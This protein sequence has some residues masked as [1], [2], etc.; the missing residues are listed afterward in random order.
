MESNGKIICV[1][2]CFYVG[3]AVEGAFV[4]LFKGIFF[5]GESEDNSENSTHNN[6][7][8][9]HSR[10]GCHMHTRFKNNFGS[11]WLHCDM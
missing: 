5:F 6:R 3:K 4:A 7:L 11:V 1:C 10:T 9:G 2:V 8:A